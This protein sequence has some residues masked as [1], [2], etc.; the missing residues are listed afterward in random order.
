MASTRASKTGVL[1]NRDGLS[2][3]NSVREIGG[4]YAVTKFRFL[5]FLCMEP[6]VIYADSHCRQFDAPNNA[7]L[8]AGMTML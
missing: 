1:R 7:S 6:T 8:Y 4:G 5:L 3:T 2:K